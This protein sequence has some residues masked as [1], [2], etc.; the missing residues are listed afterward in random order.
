MENWCMLFQGYSGGLATFEGLQYLERR[1]DHQA[2]LCKCLLA[3]LGGFHVKV[4][5]LIWWPV[6][7]MLLSVGKHVGTECILSFHKTI[8]P[9]ARSWR[10]RQGSI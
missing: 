4:S 5:R 7:K 9:P 6:R 2:G 1:S 10:C 3:H 8:M